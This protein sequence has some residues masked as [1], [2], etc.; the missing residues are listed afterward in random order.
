MRSHSEILGLKL[1]WRRSDD[2]IQP[3][4]SLICVYQIFFMHLQRDLLTVLLRATL[5][6]LLSDAPAIVLARLST[7]QPT[8]V[9]PCLADILNNLNHRSCLIKPFIAFAACQVHHSS[10]VWQW[11]C[12]LT[13]PGIFLPPS[14][15]GLLTTFSRADPHVSTSEPLS[16]LSSPS[17][18]PSHIPFSEVV[19]H[20]GKTWI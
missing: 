17:R 15:T 9:I 5:M 12:P 10:P 2:G 20:L 16:K 19:T 1:I 8:S 13:C 4:V 11:R 7:S 3:R 14:T 18:K 6:K